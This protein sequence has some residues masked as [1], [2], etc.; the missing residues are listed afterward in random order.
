MQQHRSQ[1]H[2]TQ[3]PQPAAQPAS[4][5]APQPA[6]TP[7]YK[8]TVPGC[9]GKFEKE[10]ALVQHVSDKHA[11]FAGIFYMNGGMINDVTRDQHIT[12]NYFHG[13][14]L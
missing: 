13:P 8:C 9:T 3:A 5:P 6:S 2:P 12:H 7:K 4:Q 10:S 11:S 1:K 14:G